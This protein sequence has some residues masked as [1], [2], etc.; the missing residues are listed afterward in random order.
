M[1]FG[2]A[3]DGYRKRMSDTETEPPVQIPLEALSAAALQGLLESF[4]LR[5]GTDYGAAEFTLA[6]KVAHVLSQLRRGD[7]EIVFDPVSESV[8]I[9]PTRRR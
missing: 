7:A 5:E 6:D 1:K 4:V 8:D 3:R 2:S 9:V